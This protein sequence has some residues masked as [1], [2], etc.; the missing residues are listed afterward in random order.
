MRKR[1]YIPN[2]SPFPCIKQNSLLIIFDLILQRVE[3]RKSMKN[4]LE[5]LLLVFT[6]SSFYMSKMFIDK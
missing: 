6:C 2:Y 4:N 1:I 3:C 5:N